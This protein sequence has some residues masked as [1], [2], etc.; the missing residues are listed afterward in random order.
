MR[1]LARGV[2]LD[3]LVGIA[4]ARVKGGEVPPA[5]RLVA[6]LLPQLALRREKRVFPALDLAGRELDEMAV[7]RIA[8]LPL[9]Q[10]RLGVE[11]SDHHARTG[12]PDIFAHRVV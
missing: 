6:A 10:D 11:E 2:E 7:Q 1:E 12:V 4:D 8:E 5:R 3:A 9:E